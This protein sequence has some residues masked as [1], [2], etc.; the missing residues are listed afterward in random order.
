[1]ERCNIYRLLVPWVKQGICEHCGAP[2]HHVKDSRVVL[3]LCAECM[4]CANDFIRDYDIRR[5]ER[6]LS[7]LASIYCAKFPKLVP[8]VRDYPNDVGCAVCCNHG[9]APVRRY[10]LFRNLCLECSNYLKSALCWRIHLMIKFDDWIPRDV[11]R[12]ILL[13]TM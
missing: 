13:E 7:R 11:T 3:I 10:L 4:C 5:R 8:T 6:Y 1:M 12:I 2:G 9:A